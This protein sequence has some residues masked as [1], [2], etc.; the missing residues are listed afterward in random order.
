M[1]LSPQPGGNLFCF[2]VSFYVD[3]VYKRLMA[4]REER[5]L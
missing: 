4:F 3:D 2:I 5:K 1:R